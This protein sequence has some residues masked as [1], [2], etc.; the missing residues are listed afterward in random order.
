MRKA[1]IIALVVGQFGVLAYMAGQREW[2]RHRGENIYLRTA[3]ID[4]RDPM[5]GDYVRLSYGINNVDVSHYRG[6]KAVLALSRG[7]AVYAVLKAGPVDVYD[8]DYLSDQP[9]VSGLFLRGHL[10]REVTAGQI[11]VSYGIEQYFVEQGSAHAIETKQGGLGEIQV[12]LEMAVAV[13]SSGRAVLTGFRWSRLGIRLEQI[14]PS[15]DTSN[16]L[17][18]DSATIAQRSPVIVLSLQNVSDT[19]L[20]IADNEKHCGFTLQSLGD[21]GR[22]FSAADKSCSPYV[23]VE[24]DIINLAPGEVYRIELNMGQPRW[25]VLER[26][27]SGSSAMVV[28]AASERFRLV[29]QTPLLLSGM[30]SPSLWQGSLVSPA[31]SVRGRVD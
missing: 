25:Y 22:N 19:P 14:N 5:R 8:L 27:A 20:K 3:P 11:S 15:S 10:N 24:N 31:F 7:A 9:P 30:E 4:P 29:Y 28:S 21:T 13:G 23:L 18:W 6:R 26:G 1:L 2:I 17:N 16:T 12:P